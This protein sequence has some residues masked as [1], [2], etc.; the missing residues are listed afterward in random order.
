[1]IEKHFA[2]LKKDWRLQIERPLF[3]EG[4]MRKDAHLVRLIKFLSSKDKEK[5]L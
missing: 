5:I 3:W 4:L 1:M 2:E